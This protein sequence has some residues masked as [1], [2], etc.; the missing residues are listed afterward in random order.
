MEKSNVYNLLCNSKFYK[1]SDFEYS[2]LKFEKYIKL[3]YGENIFQF[4]DH[5]FRG[6]KYFCFNDDITKNVI[7]YVEDDEGGWGWKP[8][9]VDEVK[10][11]QDN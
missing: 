11:Y 1:M 6:V 5:S 7:V 10:T 8:L 2:S 3:N 4:A 9:S